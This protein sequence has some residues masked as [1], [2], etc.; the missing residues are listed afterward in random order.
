MSGAAQERP[1]PPE[2]PRPKCCGG[3]WNGVTMVH[4]D[5]CQGRA[6]KFVSLV[7]LV[8]HMR[9]HHDGWY[10]AGIWQVERPVAEAAHEHAHAVEVRDGV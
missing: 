8:E 10:W 1:R 3:R 6:E 2:P 5:E 7:D 4:T 9:D